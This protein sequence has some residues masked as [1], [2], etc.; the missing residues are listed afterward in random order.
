M[1][2]ALHDEVAAC[3]F[4]ASLWSFTELREKANRTGIASRHLTCNWKYTGLCKTNARNGRDLINFETVERV[5][6]HHFASSCTGL[7]Y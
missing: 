6:S 5:L 2:D 4:S 1:Y 7:S 3:M